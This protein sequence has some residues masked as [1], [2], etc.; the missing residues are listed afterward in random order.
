MP[1]AKTQGRVTLADLVDAGL[2]E[3][4]D[5][6]T[7]DNHIATVQ[8]NG[9]LYVG[10]PGSIPVYLQPTYHSPSSWCTD[11]RRRGRESSATVSGWIKARLA[12]DRSRT[13]DSVRR[14]YMETIHPQG[15]PGTDATPP[16]PG[17]AYHGRTRGAAPET[18]Y[19]ADVN[20]YLD[21][22]EEDE[23]DD[24]VVRAPTSAIRRRHLVEVPPHDDDKDADFEAGEQRKKKGRS[25][26]SKAGTAAGSPAVTAGTAGSA[27]PSK[28]A[29][30]LDGPGTGKS[31]TSSAGAHRSSTPATLS[32][33]AGGAL[34]LAPAAGAG[35]SAAA[36]TTAE[37]ERKVEE[38]M[39]VPAVAILPLTTAST[40]P[41]ADIFRAA[42]SC[43][44]CSAVLHAD[45][46][47]LTC[48]SCTEAHH[49]SCT[50]LY[51]CP[52]PATARDPWICI[53]CTFCSKCN[54]STPRDQLAKCSGCQ[55][56]FHLDCVHVSPDLIGADG[57]IFC[58]NC[59]EC[60]SC[61]T[62]PR[63]NVALAPPA[64]DRHPAKNAYQ[65]Q[66]CSASYHADNYCPVCLKAYPEDDFETPMVGCD[67]PCGK[68]VHKACD[69]LLSNIHYDELHA[70]N[71]EYVCPRCR[72]PPASEADPDEVMHVD[73][74]PAVAAPVVAA[75]PVVSKIS[76][77]VT[78]PPDMLD[79]QAADKMAVDESVPVTTVQ[80]DPAA[81]AIADALATTAI[82]DATDATAATAAP[83]AAA[84]PA[85]TDHDMH[86]LDDANKEPSM[87]EIA[88]RTYMS[89]RECAFC[90]Q[91][92]AV[93]S[94][95]GR[96]L[97]VGG[98]DPLSLG[99]G[100]WVHTGC[101]HWSVTSPDMVMAADAVTAAVTAMQPVTC[102]LC[103]RGSANV[104]CQSASCKTAYHWACLVRALFTEVPAKA[105]YGTAADLKRAHKVHLDVFQKHFRCATH[106][107]PGT[108]NTAFRPYLP[109]LADCERVC[110]MRFAIQQPNT[111][112]LYVSAAPAP[113]PGQLLTTAP[114]YDP[115][116][117]VA[118]GAIVT[119]IGRL[120]FA[121][122]NWL[123][124][125]TRM[126]P[127]LV[128]VGYTVVRRF[129]SYKRP[130]TVTSLVISR[131]VDG[132]DGDDGDE[133]AATAARALEA[134]SI[135]EGT[136]I[137]GESIPD[138][139][140]VDT[141]EITPARAASLRWRVRIADDRT[142][143]FDARAM[144][145]IM[146]QLLARFDPP[147]PI[148]VNHHYL[149][150]PE[151][152][153][154]LHHP[155]IV[156]FIENLP[157]AAQA[158]QYPFRYV[159][160]HAALATL[161]EAERALR[162]GAAR[163]DKRT[164]DALVAE[165]AA[166]RRPP[167]LAVD[168]SLANVNGVVGSVAAAVG[169]TSPVRA[170]AA[171]RIAHVKHA[172]EPSAAAGASTPVPPPSTV[173][174]A[175]PAAGS[176]S[177]RGDAVAPPAPTVWETTIPQQLQY[178]KLKASEHAH[179]TVKPSKI[180]GVGLFAERSFQ[181]HDMIIEYLGQVVGQKVA[182]ARELVNDRR[183]IGT[184]FF[185]IEHD[186]ILDATTCGNAARFINHSCEPNCYARIVAPVQGV[187]RVVIYA[188]RAVQAGEELTYD[189]KFQ[190]EE[191]VSKRIRCRCGASKCRGY[192]N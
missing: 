86:D 36:A 72:T 181:A 46:E 18:D 161:R 12:A 55:H 124:D 69:P 187:R 68:W 79:D 52:P 9:E 84:P 51:I 155:V 15:V 136:V 107:T 91:T 31:R 174:P 145:E 83:A 168:T 47:Y 54:K 21:E 137:Q 178:Q 108:A 81:S 11:V 78:P 82:T 152:L 30:V 167:A 126:P 85:A 132:D 43:V 173:K 53:Y 35:P 141:Y 97:F 24:D 170:S 189:Y 120:P 172:D 162:R 73:D 100:Q 61:G 188:L 184:Y 17:G 166:R 92:A 37:L 44:D 190:P 23:D 180:Q 65:C 165:M 112:P 128:P 129:W 5:Q 142:G 40:D 67:G 192:M 182:D 95:I 48:A 121:D 114:P 88:L 138:R 123:M 179:C 39:P 28:K 6:V 98:P 56:V 144:A 177:A 131:V 153:V 60:F 157:H 125:R 110:Q 143:A 8:A 63:G 58:N 116:C 122:P 89:G 26:P 113:Q 185:A 111:V 176:A 150:R 29:K 106:A 159:E 117:L 66:S 41:D 127:V 160:D 175:V 62:K 1:P 45:E 42:T 104:R 20:A 87:A 32:A 90:H 27:P 16:P 169:P 13:L 74:V 186:R 14:Q 71:H 105:G 22:D 102:A 33:A 76:R 19:A 34:G 171:A 146:P 133:H 80:P 115:A 77:T 130:G 147:F 99:L 7:F 156:R 119:H 191:D 183:G 94:G 3:A 148:A 59:A 118:G 109:R 158:T 4:G 163:T 134:A 2:L 10:E 154:L 96:L 93:P 135:D 164:A 149:T 75:A 38:P 140:I 49:P 50:P 101:L 57:T 25:R 139:T 64:W 70:T 103:K 151:S